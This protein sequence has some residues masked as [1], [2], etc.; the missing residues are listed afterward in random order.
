MKTPQ[1]NEDARMSK[2]TA[3]L[4]TPT[5]KEGVRRITV[6]SDSNHKA[7]R[8]VPGCVLLRCAVVQ[9]S[10]LQECRA[11]GMQQSLPSWPDTCHS[12]CSL[13]LDVLH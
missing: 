5:K 11:V 7:G 12:V 1:N 8:S 4:K 13:F 10:A 6:S 2:A 9:S 3:L